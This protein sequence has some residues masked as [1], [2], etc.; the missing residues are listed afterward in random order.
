MNIQH[1]LQML[2]D[3]LVVMASVRHCKVAYMKSMQ[4]CSCYV[5]CAQWLGIKI[6]IS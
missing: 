1:C 3:S 5:K 2:Y 6:D 4:K